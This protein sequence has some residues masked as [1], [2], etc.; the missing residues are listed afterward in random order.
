M[1][2][3]VSPLPSLYNVH[4]PPSLSPP[5]SLSS[6]LFPSTTHKPAD[7]ARNIRTKLS[8]ESSSRPAIVF[9]LVGKDFGEGSVK[10]WGAWL[11]QLRRSS[12]H[13]TI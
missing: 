10:V 11:R 13:E 4:S 7:L 6:P 1:Y 8:Q 2:M 3:Y 9:A 12:R 5:F